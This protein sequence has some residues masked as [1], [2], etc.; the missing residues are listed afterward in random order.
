[1]EFETPNELLGR[2]KLGREREEY[3]QRLL[4]TLILHGLEARDA[5]AATPAG[6]PLRHELPWIWQPS[7]LGA[8]LTTAG[9]DCGMELR[10]SR[11]ATPRY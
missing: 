9:N 7:S 3:C 4:T 2:L 1:M 8:P 5:L 6:S 11:Y 10:V